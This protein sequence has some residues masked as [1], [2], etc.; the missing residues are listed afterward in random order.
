MA[1]ARLGALGER[2]GGG[3]YT[4]VYCGLTGTG[5]WPGVT[6]VRALRAA[7]P[8]RSLPALPLPR[9]YTLALPFALVAYLR[10]AGDREGE[11][12]ISYAEQQRA[13]VAAAV[14]AGAVCAAVGVFCAGVV[15]DCADTLYVC[16]LVDRATGAEGRDGERQEVW[17]A[18]RIFFLVIPLIV[19]FVAFPFVP[20][21]IL[22]RNANTLTSST[23]RPPTRRATPKP[24]SG[25]PSTSTLVAST[26]GAASAGAGAT[27]ASGLKTVGRVGNGNGNA[28]GRAKSRCT[29]GCGAQAKRRTGRCPRPLRPLLSRCRS[30]SAGSRRPGRARPSPRRRTHGPCRRSRS[31]MTRTRTWTRLTR[32][33]GAGRA[34]ARSLGAGFSSAAVTDAGWRIYVRSVYTTN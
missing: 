6:G 20:T 9:P 8:E 4:G 3:R 17:G 16:H 13:A 30:R 5:F 31:R 12:G 25:S 24:A 15:R 18:V 26:S 10:A 28:A 23:L 29:R 19:Y 1:L 14:L 33:A 2:I 7:A 11:E 22:I 21:L 27:R 34:R 32:G